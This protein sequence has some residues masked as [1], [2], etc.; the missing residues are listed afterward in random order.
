MIEFKTCYCGTKFCQNNKQ[1]YCSLKCV[2][3]HTKD[4]YAARANKPTRGPCLACG[5][6]ID[7][8]AHAS[9]KK[10]CSRDCQKKAYFPSVSASG[11][12]SGRTGTL[13]ELVVAV[14]LIKRG[15]DVYRALEIG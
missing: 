12:T 13:H 10:Y 7:P 11:M 6:S 9:R 15:C 8:S 5:G 4:A 2:N 14:D 3:G 1:K